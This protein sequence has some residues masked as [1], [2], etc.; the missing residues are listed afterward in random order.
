VLKINGRNVP[1]THLRYAF[2][3]GLRDVVGMTG[4]KF[5]C[6]IACARLHGPLSTETRRGH[7]SLRSPLSAGKASR[8]SKVRRET[9]EVRRFQK[10]WLAGEVPP[11]RLLPIWANHVRVRTFESESEAERFRIIDKVMSGN[12]CRCGTTRGFR[13]IKVAARNLAGSK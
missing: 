3:V 11:V 1:A 10:S 7:A 8:R 12:V 5:G 13:G 9:P 4:T 6:G 2:A